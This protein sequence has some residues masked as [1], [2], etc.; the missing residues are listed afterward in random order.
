VL[1]PP[2]ATA[3]HLVGVLRLD[4]EHNRIV[5][6]TKDQLE[7]RRIILRGLN[8][9]IDKKSFECEVKIRYRTHKV[10]ARVKIDESVAVVEILEPVYGVAKGQACVFYEGEKVLGGG[11]IV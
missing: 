2:A 1:T 8:M 7:K 3:R 9:F 11:W 10:P 5:V 6:G 4:P